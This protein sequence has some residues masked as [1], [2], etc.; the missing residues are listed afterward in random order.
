[1]EGLVISKAKINTI[2]KIETMSSVRGEK[3][4]KGKSSRWLAKKKARVEQLKYSVQHI[5]ETYGFL[6]LLIQIVNFLS[7]KRKNGKFNDLDRF[8]DSQGQSLLS[9]N[10]PD[11]ITYEQYIQENEPTE[12]GL[13][14]Q[15]SIE[16]DFNYRPLISIITP[17]YNTDLKML[18]DMIESVFSQTYS[19]WELCLIDGCSTKLHVRPVLE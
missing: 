8:I 10:L 16:M 18:R 5:R 12:A 7:G 1:M 2:P 17:V 15:K 13:E 19:N 9:K 3:N 14:I 4:T 6:P 11:E